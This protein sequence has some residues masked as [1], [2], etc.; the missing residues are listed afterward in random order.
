MQRV[1]GAGP[2]QAGD[3]IASI[4][5]LRGVAVLGI[6]I[7]NIV[8]FGLV[9]PA[10]SNPIPDGALTGVNF[11]TYV[12]VEVLFEGSMRAIFSMLFGAG[13][14]FIHRAGRQSRRRQP[15]WRI[16]TTNAPFC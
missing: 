12:S 1:S 9:S 3:R 4:D 10:F 6:L 15:R 13:S 16:S 14:H 7:L 8:A 2:V 11:W 5:T